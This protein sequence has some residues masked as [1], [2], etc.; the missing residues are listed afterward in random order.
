M[1][2]LV[3]ERWRRAN[4]LSDSLFKGTGEALPA[5]LVGISPWTDLGLVGA[6]CLENERRIQF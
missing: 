4:F 2:F 5:K 3:G 1:N 6:S